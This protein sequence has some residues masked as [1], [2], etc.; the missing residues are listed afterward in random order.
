LKLIKLK[1]MRN[2]FLFFCLLLI[3]PVIN[4]AQNVGIGTTNPS[5]KLHVTDPSNDVRV[6]VESPAVG[7]EAEIR[8]LAGNNP[9]SFLQFSKYAPGALGSYAGLPKDNLSVI[10]AGGNGG[11][12]VLSTGDGVSPVIIA[13][14]AGEQM[15][16]TADGRIAIG[17]NNPSNKLHVHDGESNQDASIVLTNNLT[18]TNAL[19]GGRFRFLNSDLIIFN[20]EATGKIQFNTAFNT[21]MTI[22]A[23]GNVGIGT[24]SPNNKLD[25]VAGGFSV[26][27]NIEQSGS[28]PAIKATTPAGSSQ[29]GL[30]LDNGAIKV[31]GANR[32]VFQHTATAGNT[33]SNETEIPN[34]SFANAATDMIIITPVWDGIYVNAPIGV[35]FSGSTW[36]IFRQDLAAMPVGAKFNVLVIKQ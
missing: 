24:T 22:D 10:A 19:R 2:T 26:G 23:V 27:V 5:V 25:I 9:F 36:R 3:C 7:S 20:Y 17:T 29:I 21:R 1:I 28:V 32:T 11:S 6:L 35:Y 4:Y 31:S 34:T 8:L 33:L 14:G 16:I 13:A 30:E 18:G 12:M 15:R